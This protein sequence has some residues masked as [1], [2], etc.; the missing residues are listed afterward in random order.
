MRKFLFLIAACALFAQ[1]VDAKVVTVDQAK[2][3]ARRQFA[4]PTKLNA[5]NVN[6]TLNYQAR[7]LKGETDFYVF[8]NEGGEGFVIVS[9]D[10]LTLPVLGYSDMGSFDINN[11][12]DGLKFLL[13]QYQYQIEWLRTHPEDA[14]ITANRDIVTPVVYALLGDY[15]WWQ[16]APYNSLLPTASNMPTDCRGHCYVGCAGHAM[17]AIMR[18]HKHPYH[19]FGENTY[20]TDVQ[21]REVTLSANFANSYYKWSNMRTGYGPTAS[22][23]GDVAKLMYDVDVAVNMR[24]YGDDGSEAYYRDIVKA[25]VAYF[26]Y[27]PTIQFLMKSNYYGDWNALIFHELDEGRPV[28]YFGNKTKDA[29]GNTVNIGHA[30]IIDGYDTQDRVHINW[31]FQPEAYN[32]WFS[33]DMLSPK[34]ESQYEYDQYYEGF[35]GSQGAIIGIMPDTTNT[36]GVVVKGGINLYADVMPANDVRG[37]FDIQALNGPYSGTIRWAIAAKTSEGWTN[38]STP[39][40]VQLNLAENEIATIDISGSYQLYEGRTYYVV[41]WSPYFPNNYSWNWWLTPPEPFTVGDW[42]TPPEPEFPLG[43]V[44]HDGEVDVL[45]VT[46]LISYILGENPEGFYLD[47]ANVDGDDEGA[48]DVGDVTAAIALILD[49]E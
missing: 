30:Y 9:G 16:G 7:N 20:T 48:I 44:N 19:G 23:A 11:A 26:D 28:Y 8:N 18:Y 45:D 2:A 22:N 47:V 31:G 41:I 40:N 32:G 14:K 15:H 21:G 46:M 37:S 3:I 36:G 49:G 25:F 6:M 43:D 33:M 4:N 38:Y 34:P 1:S 10:D 13:E 39:Q 12:P 42:P 29:N 35:N 27:A 24:F 5:S 17:A